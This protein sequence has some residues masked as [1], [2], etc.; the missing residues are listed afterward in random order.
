[1]PYLAST[2]AVF[3]LNH[4]SIICDVCTGP[5]LTDPHYERKQVWLLFC[6][7]SSQYRTDKSATDMMIDTQLTEA[8]CSKNIRA[9]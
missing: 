2:A 1:M 7:A 6:L 4:S 5:S 9:H 3:I 8:V